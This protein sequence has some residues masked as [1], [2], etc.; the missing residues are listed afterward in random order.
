M[1]DEVKLHFA[2]KIASASAKRDASIARLGL[3]LAE[4]NNALDAL[5]RSSIDVDGDDDDES[6]A[7][8]RPRRPRH[9]PRPIRPPLLTPGRSATTLATITNGASRDD[10][11][12]RNST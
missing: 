8:Q 4:Q 1:P 12:K 2:D 9:L 7:P 5:Y 6:P 3:D 10:K 11:I